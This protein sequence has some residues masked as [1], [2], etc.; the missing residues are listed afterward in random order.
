MYVNNFLDGSSAWYPGQANNPSGGVCG[1]LNLGSN[2]FVLQ[3]V[4]GHVEMDAA[5]MNALYGITACPPSFNSDLLL[6]LGTPAANGGIPE[7][8]KFLAAS[9]LDLHEALHLVSLGGKTCRCSRAQAT[10]S[11]D[12]LTGIRRSHYRCRCYISTRW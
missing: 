10:A 2:R 9:D 1:Q 12:M 3:F 11:G 7:I 6:D 8:E 4:N 5:A